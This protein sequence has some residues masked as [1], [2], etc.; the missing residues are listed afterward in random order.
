[1]RL[2]LAIIVPLQLAFGCG[3]PSNPGPLSRETGAVGYLPD[4]EGFAGMFAGVSDDCLVMAG[5][6]NF[7]N[8]KPWAGGKKVWTNQVFRQKQHGAEVEPVGTLPRPLG[9]GVSVTWDDAVWCF[10]GS[11]AEGH[12]ADGFRLRLR[13]GRLEILPLPAL[14]KPCAN[15]SGAIV[16]KTLHVAGGIETPDATTGLNTHWTLDLSDERA[17]WRE[18]SP[19]PGTPRMFAVGGSDGTAFYLFSGA[20]LSPDADGKPKREYLKDCWRYTNEKWERLPDL[21][22][23]AA[24][25]PCPA[26]F[27]GQRLHIL[28]GDDGTYVGFQPLEQ[29]PGFPTTA[30]AFDP[31]TGVWQEVRGG[32]ES[33]VCVPAVEWKGWYRFPGGEPRPGVRLRTIGQ[34][35]FREPR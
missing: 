33:R 7:P 28:S 29:H 9:Y 1:M 6:A 2:L 16:G 11:N 35:T 30:F 4:P 5:G 3:S 14:P 24:A 20:A 8:Q 25:A 26:P 18:R 23:A 12:F 19:C 31:S 22:R 10:G 27:D 15:M 13:D 17:Q 21:P 32:S 34:I